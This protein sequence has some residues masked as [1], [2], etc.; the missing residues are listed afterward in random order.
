MV[1]RTGWALPREK[2]RDHI[3]PIPEVRRPP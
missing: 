3:F 1:K 2:I